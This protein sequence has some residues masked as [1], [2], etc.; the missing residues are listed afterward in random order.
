MLQ[1]MRAPF[2]FSVIP[3]H[4]LRYFITLATAELIALLIIAFAAAPMIYSSDSGK[5]PSTSLSEKIL[6]VGKPEVA[7]ACNK[8]KPTAAQEQRVIPSTKRFGFEQN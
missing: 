1:V 8:L 3:L 2:S 6:V 7:P 5:A 4:R